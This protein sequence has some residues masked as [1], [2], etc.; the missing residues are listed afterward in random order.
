M[1]DETQQNKFLGICREAL[2]NKWVLNL[3][4]NLLNDFIEVFQRDNNLAWNQGRGN[5]LGPD[6]FKTGIPFMSGDFGGEKFS[7]V[8]WAISITSA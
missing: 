2:Q 7:V 4:R 1:Q 5:S 8:F 3:G 6:G